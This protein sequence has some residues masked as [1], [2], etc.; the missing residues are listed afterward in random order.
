MNVYHTQW[1]VGSHCDATKMGFCGDPMAQ[2]YSLMRWGH[3][4][5]LSQGLNTSARWIPCI[6]CTT[7]VGRCMGIHW[8]IG[9]DRCMKG[10]RCMATY[11]SAPG[12]GCSSR[13]QARQT[14]THPTSCGFAANREANPVGE[15]PSTAATWSGRLGRPCFLI[16]QESCLSLWHRY[17]KFKNF[18]KTMCRAGGTTWDGSC[19]V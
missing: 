2:M 3:A 15:V 6:V 16:P 14:S 10:A 12:V 17:A 18:T 8:C 5:P 13:L 7:T 1:E 4:V 11:S 9:S 19:T